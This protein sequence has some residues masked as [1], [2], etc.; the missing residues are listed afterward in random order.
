MEFTR[1]GYEKQSDTIKDEYINYTKRV[2]KL[3]WVFAGYLCQIIH[4]RFSIFSAEL[5]QNESRH[6]V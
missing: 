1:G 4:F 6:A 2:N 5:Y 3:V